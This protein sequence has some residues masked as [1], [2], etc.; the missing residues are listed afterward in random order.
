MG[1][2]RFS[3]IRPLSKKNIEK[4]SEDNPILYKILNR[5]GGNV[6]TGVS[7]R[8]QGQDR[9]KDHLSGGSDPIPGAVGFK[10]KEIPSIER[11]KTEETRI[12]KKEDPK[13]NKRS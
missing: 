10:T 7:K 9:L 13:Y 11:A 3:P 2:K 12:I 1:K 5:Q 6:Y 8:G 4:T